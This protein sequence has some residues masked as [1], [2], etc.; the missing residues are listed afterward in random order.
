MRF[1]STRPTSAP[2]PVAARQL[3]ALLA[4]ALVVLGLGAAP[5]HATTTRATTGSCVDGGG[6][7]WQTK[8]I[9]G[10]TYVTSDGVTKVSVDYAGW[11]STLGTIATDSRV[12]TYDGAGRQVASLTRTATVNYRQGVVS[13]ARNPVN[14]TSGGAQIVIRLGRDADGFGNCS[15][16][17]SQSATADPVVAAVGDIACKP[18]AVTTAKTCQQVAVSNSILA[19]RPARVLT[20][21]DNQYPDGTLA[22]YRGAYHRSF[23]RLRAITSPAPGNHEYHTSGAAGYYAYFG[24]AAGERT[25]GY[26]SHDVGSWHVVVLNSERDIRATG[27]QLTWLKKDL[28]AH[29]NRCT[30]AVLH[31]PRFSS[32]SHGS[33]AA[34]KPFFDALVSARA[35]LLLAGHDHDYERFAPQTGAGVASASGLT[36]VVS[37]AGGKNLYGF[38]SRVANSV[39]RSSAGFGWLKL[40]LRPTRADLQFVGVAGNTYRDRTTVTCR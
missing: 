23:G 16:A 25:K 14:P 20:L 34:M 3:S 8:V 31:K 6:V 29:P 9:W 12:S 27:A 37:G 11:S 10:S 32:G 19:A 21:G 26:Y 24:T 39:A 28:A 13:A 35:D 40:T 7:T 18:G 30:L 2:L 36:E 22:Q 4:L 17:H 15:V 38:G 33:N 5:A 1:G